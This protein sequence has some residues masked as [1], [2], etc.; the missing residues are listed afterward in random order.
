[1]ST[2]GD[3]P[4]M[5]AQT[6]APSKTRHLQDVS[7]LRRQLSEDKEVEVQHLEMAQDVKDGEA[8]PL[9]WKNPD[10]TAYVKLRL[11]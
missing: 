4:S 11:R 6:E 9:K 1:M 2:D 7:V 5:A 3:R 8:L 10:V